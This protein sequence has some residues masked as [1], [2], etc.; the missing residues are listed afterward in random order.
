MGKP[1]DANEAW[2]LGLVNHVFE[3]ASLMDETQTLAK[4]LARQAPIATRF[5]LDA[6]HRGNELPLADGQN[7]EATL[8]GL[9]ASTED[10]REGLQAFL[11]K[12]KAEFKG[13]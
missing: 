13:C 6:V 5:I 4:K 1:I 11:D 10:T 3:A 2:R 9:I 12:R 8:F 7:L